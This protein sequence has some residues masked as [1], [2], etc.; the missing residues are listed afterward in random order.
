MSRDGGVLTLSANGGPNADDAKLAEW[1]KKDHAAVE[2]ILNKKQLAALEKLALRHNFLQGLNTTLYAGTCSVAERGGLLR[3][4]E[5][6]AAQWKELC[7]L[8][9][10]KEAM[11]YRSFRAI[12]D[13]ALKILS[14]EQQDKFIAEWARVFAIPPA[15]SPS[16]IDGKKGGLTKV[17]K[18]FLIIQGTDAEADEKHATKADVKKPADS[19]KPAKTK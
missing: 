6:S 4:I 9:D 17:G 13:G 3:R 15:G 11:M 16:T 14:P 18:G 8:Y 7:R 19:A 10:E 1:L 5:L 2:R 12:G